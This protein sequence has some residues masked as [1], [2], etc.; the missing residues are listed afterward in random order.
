MKN[1][2]KNNHN[3]T[4]KTNFYIY[5]FATFASVAYIKKEISTTDPFVLSIHARVDSI[6]EF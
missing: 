3:H 1:T 2:L 4:G 5:I 6:H